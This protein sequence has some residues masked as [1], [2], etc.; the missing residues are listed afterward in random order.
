MQQQAYIAAQRH[1]LRRR[2]CCTEHRGT[3]F[4]VDHA[5]PSRFNSYCLSHSITYLGQSHTSYVATMACLF[6]WQR[7]SCEGCISCSRNTIRSR[8]SIWL[9]FLVITRAWILCH[10]SNESS[11]WVKAKLT[12]IT[13]VASPQSHYLPAVDFT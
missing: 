2:P 5:A 3:A 13:V 8:R 12:C 9:Y 6:R 7:K 11:K 1:S 4:A 10:R